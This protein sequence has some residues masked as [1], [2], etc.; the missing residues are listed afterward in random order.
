[1]SLD[2]TGISGWSQE[3]A[4]PLGGP[5][6]CHNDVFPENAVFPDG[7]VIALIDFAVAA[8]GRAFWDVAI[9]AQERA[10]LHAPAARLDHPRHLDGVARLGLMARAYGVRPN[11]APE[12]VDVIFAERAQSVGHIRSQVAAGDLSGLATGNNGAVK[13]GRRPT[14]HG[15]IFIARRSGMSSAAGLAAARENPAIRGCLEFMARQR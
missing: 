9:A 4:D 13:S 1:M 8:P 15:S 12:L 11:D 6:I 5:V 7:R 3:W 10:P 2:L 14:M